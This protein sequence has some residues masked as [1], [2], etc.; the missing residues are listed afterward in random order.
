[1]YLT[2]S[3]AAEPLL[4][5][6]KVQHFLFFSVEI[7]FAGC[8]LR[9]LSF[10]ALIRSPLFSSAPATSLFSATVFPEFVSCVPSAASDVKTASITDESS[11][12][13]FSEAVIF[14]CLGRLSS[15]PPHPV[16]NNA[17]SAASLPQFGQIMF[18]VSF[19]FFVWY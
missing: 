19:R 18:H 5:T 12:L 17:P 1:M 4:Q 7:L 15:L 10:A 6:R 13:L 16:Q 11:L 14:S 3:P 2:V 9:L 8:A